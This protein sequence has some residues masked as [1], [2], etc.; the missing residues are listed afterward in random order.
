MI[1]L[2]DM[3]FGISKIQYS[4]Q[5]PDDLYLLAAHIKSYNPIFYRENHINFTLTKLSLLGIF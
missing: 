2:D 4:V 1:Y 5:F 3:M